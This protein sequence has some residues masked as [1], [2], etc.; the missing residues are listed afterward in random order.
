MK[1]S[2]NIYCGN[3]ENNKLHKAFAYYGVLSLYDDDPLYSQKVGG[4]L[5][6]SVSE[7]SV[8]R[9]VGRSLSQDYIQKECKRKYN[10]RT[11]SIPGQTL[12]ALE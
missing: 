2:K 1:Y 10:L 11:L 6:E 8:G 3:S 4:W 7:R 5:D 9:L 12:K